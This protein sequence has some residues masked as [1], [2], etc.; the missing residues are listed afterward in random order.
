MIIV[1]STD[2]IGPG[3]ALFRPEFYTA[4]HR[5]LAHGG[6]IVQQSESPLTHLPILERMYRN[7]YA[8]AFDDVRTL[9]FPQPIYPSGWWS[10]TVG[11][12]G[13]GIEGFRE[14]AVAERGFETRYYNAEI[15]R[16]AFATPEFFQRAVEKWTSRGTSDPA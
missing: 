8:A 16:A 15:H 7:L 12:K 9:F 10:A 3:E 1:D 4:A 6:M 14:D 2:P 5:A 11:R 13:G